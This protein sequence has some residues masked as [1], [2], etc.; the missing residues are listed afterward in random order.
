METFSILNFHLLNIEER[1]L[2]L[3]LESKF[4][5]KK[6]LRLFLWTSQLKILI[7]ELGNKALGPV[8]VFICWKE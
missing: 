7:I 3:Y 4:Y 8:F 2:Q 1:I 6:R 5:R